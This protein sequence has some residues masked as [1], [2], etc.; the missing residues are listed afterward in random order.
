MDWIAPLLALTLMEIVLGIDN[1]VF[2][3]VLAGRLPKEQQA[4]GRNVGLLLA[5]GMRIALLLTLKYVIDH[6]TGSLFE[7]TDLGVPA[8]WLPDPLS[9]EAAEAAAHAA[10]TA[11]HGEEHE[12]AFDAVNRI[13][14]KDIVMLLGGLF[15][16]YKSVHEIHKK[17]EGHDHEHAT[18]EQVSLASVLFQI[19]MIDIVF[20]L[21]SVITAIGMARDQWI[22][23]VA[24]VVAVVFMLVFSGAISRFIEKHPTVKMLALS[25]LLLIGVMLIAESAGQHINKGYIYFAMAFSLLVEV[26]NLRMKATRQS[27]LRPGHAPGDI[28]RAPSPD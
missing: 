5:L 19:A 13:T 17:I 21:D 20:S 2:I 28:H 7:L 3:A 23:I 22:M 10:E 16:L 27:R 8:S 12:S 1:V 15:L 6:L 11:G 24:I 25:F 14:G 26:L 9:P 18:N 4:L